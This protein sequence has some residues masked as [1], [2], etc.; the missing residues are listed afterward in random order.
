MK[1]IHDSLAHVFQRDR[2][3][4]WYDSTGEWA[5]AFDSFEGA[6]VEKLKVEGNEFGTKVRVVRDPDPDARF[7]V[8]VP[9]LRPADA[10]NWLLDL[11]LQ[12]YE[13]KADK[14]SLALHEV[15]L[16]QEFLPL[17]EEHAAFF[18]SEKR[19]QALKARVSQ[20]DE[21][22]EIRLKMMGVLADTDDEVDA[23]LLQFLGS[24]F[25]GSTMQM[26]DPV[27]ECLDRAALAEPFWREVGRAFG[28]S[29]ATPS[30]KDFA[31][32]LFRSA[33]PLDTQATLHPHAKVFL[34][35]WK[36]SQTHSGSFRD[37]AHLMEREMRIEDA[38]ERADGRT[39]LGDTDTFEIFEKFILHRLCQA[40]DKGS[41]ATELRAVMQQRRTSFWYPLY[42]H[43]YAA[44]E[45]A[46][47]MRELLASAELTVDSMAAGVSR[48]MGSWWRIDMAYRLCRMHLRE[49][50]QLN[51]MKQ[52][53]AWLEKTYVNNFLLPLAD[54]WG[55]QVR[56]LSVWECDALQAQRIFF[57]IHVR[58]FLSKGQKV[59]V[60]VS[61]G[62]RYEAA[63]DFA[64]RLRSANRWTAEVSA[65]LGQL[66]SYTQLGMASLLPGKQLS[67]DPGT[68]Y[69]SVDG[70]SAT[71][72]PNRA[73]ILRLACD[74]RATA[75][76]AGDFLELNTK[77]DGR[78][79]MRDHDVI[80]IFHNQIDEIGDAG[81][82]EKKTVD[83]VE[84][85]F[86]ELD[87]I[88]R[89]VANINGSNM[90]LTAD[91]GFLFQQDDVDQGD[92]SK[93]PAA[94]EWTFPGQRFAIGRGIAE[95]AAVKVFSAEALGLS[96]EWSAAFPLSLG[97]F[98]RAGSGKRY[99][100]G[101]ISLQ[102]V[103]VPVVRIHKARADDTG[104]VEVDLLRVPAKITTGQLAIALFQ[105]RPAIDKVLSRTLRI[106]V[107]ASD[108]S[109]ISEIKTVTFDSKD[110]EAR[111][112]E[113]ALLLVL[114]H[115][116]DQF[117]GREVELRLEERVQ[118]SEHFVTYKAHNLKLQKPF[119]SDFD[120]F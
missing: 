111:N 60:I 63:A 94:E 20:D 77:T 11:L 53:T 100:H 104:R 106:G 105:G 52:L 46:V 72:T 84:D 102:E 40:F 81:K 96:G 57:D 114:S 61:D 78:A 87:Q 35:R 118:G 37:W 97:R 34:R 89:K 2:I 73:E 33:N 41:A 5:E 113:T 45:Q 91:H 26:F 101:G 8:Y 24:A 17:A 108:D 92:M 9:A 95:D 65:V 103:V 67:V 47:E 1:R 44:L 109:S 43:G 25:S 27:V 112:R 116:A 16:R 62:L 15:G 18:R 4:F 30:L 19:T 71:G 55:D 22:R 14:A 115:A 48:Y 59:F 49:Y 75:M 107:Y 66:P 54:R 70:R 117:N 50:A 82:T 38:L 28:Y 80:Y 79:L 68:S 74:G 98:P 12:G 99:V 13:Y 69:A 93:L 39:N 7:L 56:R 3:V 85:A 31:V 120:E 64:Q 119:A 51:L 10:N 29:S 23:L 6:G 42:K 32:S 86:D 90:V 58:P 110:P 76:Q 21:A 36:D 83:A 88:I